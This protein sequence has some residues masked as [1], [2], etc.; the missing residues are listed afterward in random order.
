M[1]ATSLAA[2]LPYL[3]ERSVALGLD[4]LLV[5]KVLK[6]FKERSSGNPQ[7]QIPAWAESGDKVIVA[8]VFTSPPGPLSCKA[9]W[10]FLSL[11]SCSAP[12]YSTEVLGFLFL[13]IP[14]WFIQQVVIWGLF[15]ALHR[16]S[17][18]D[19]VVDQSDPAPAPRELSSLRISRWRYWGRSARVFRTGLEAGAG[20]QGGP[21]LK[22]R[23]VRS[24]C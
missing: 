13:N 8:L 6:A 4:F 20:N 12:W 7:T 2:P 1:W 9:V 11:R 5:A 21:L 10:T 19:A 14:C 15:Y 18:R 16:T 24:F 23:L 17:F 22:E 3:L